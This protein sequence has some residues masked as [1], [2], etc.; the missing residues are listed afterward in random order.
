MFLVDES[1]DPHDDMRH[2]DL[3]VTEQNIDVLAATFAAQHARTLPRK[4]NA[5][6]K[7]YTNI[8]Y[9]TLPISLDVSKTGKQSNSDYWNETYDHGDSTVECVETVS[10]TTSNMLTEYEIDALFK[11]QSKEQP[12]KSVKRCKKK[13]ETAV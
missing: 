5:G 12:L 6:G 9:S 3:A 10:V 11:A 7:K 13:S 2:L 8:C 4:S 1:V